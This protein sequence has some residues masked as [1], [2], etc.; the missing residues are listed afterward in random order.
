MGQED[1]DFWQLRLFQYKIMPQILL[2][3]I[4]LTTQQ[5]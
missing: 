1:F 3:M 4:Q 5:P 2:I